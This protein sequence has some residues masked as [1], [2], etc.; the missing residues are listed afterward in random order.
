[1]EI[2]GQAIHRPLS[3]PEQAFLPSVG[4]LESAP[5]NRS[6]GW[7]PPLLIFGVALL[8]RALALPLATF[9]AGDS[10]ARIWLAWKWADHPTLITHGVWGPLHFYLIGLALR[11]WTD[12]VWA[13]AVLHVMLGA[14]VPV[15]VY[16]LTLAIFGGQRAALVTSLAFAVYPAAVAVSLFALSEPPFM[17]FLGLGLL[18]L[19]RAHRSTGTV[20][21]AALA[22][23]AIGAASMLRYEAWLLLPFLALP[24]IRRPKQLLAF[25]VPALTHP[26]VWMIGNAIAYH[27][28]L[29]SFN[30]ASDW[31]RKA[32]GH[33][34]LVSFAWGAARVW[35]FIRVTQAGLTPPLCLL[36]TFGVLRC[37]WCRRAE[38]IWLVPPLGLFALIVGAAARG[39][40]VVKWEYTPSFGLMLLPFCACALQALGIEGWPRRRFVAATVVL[41]AAIVLFTIEPLWR[42][43]PH[44]EAFLARMIPS[45]PAM[46]NARAVLAL[47]D[48]GRASGHEALLSDFYGWQPTHYVALHT[49]LPPARIC[50]V[51]GAPNQPLR[52]AAVE[53]FLRDHRQ[54]VLISQEQGKLGSMLQTN[55]DQTMGL[56]DA[57]LHL[58]PVGV[59][60]WP[61][62]ANDTRH[63][64]VIRV[65]RYSVVGAATAPQSARTTAQSCDSD[66]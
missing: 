36:V 1:V 4:N 51:S 39:S 16:E 11:V 31:E 50:M 26:A 35:E 3:C 59:V 60:Q 18:F 58:E 43:V 10:A 66:E 7:R 41:L 15:V 53:A 17:L 33:A 8:V 14:C 37:L 2:P 21:D 46:Q 63:N 62:T 22:G 57:R 9:D 29:Y 55:P 49:K 12:P 44:G 23:L 47:V 45:F 28:P 65:A 25:L 24:V 30:W 54:G 20:L 42:A 48:Q 40:L 13:P 61:P 34:Q 19:V 6:V 52:I 64:I 5:A 32:M 27:D 56:G 38:A